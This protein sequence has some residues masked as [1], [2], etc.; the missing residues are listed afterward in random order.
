MM[1]SFLDWKEELASIEP[2]GEMELLRGRAGEST[3]RID[4]TYL[5]SRYRPREEAA[6]L[7][8]DAGL[9]LDRPILVVGLGLGY[10]VAAL[11]ARGATQ[12]AGIEGGKAVA[13]LALQAGVLDAYD[14]LLGLGKMED[15]VDT[16]AYHSFA[17]SLPQVLVH[18][19]TA[20]LHP[21]Y[22]EA[23]VVS[24]SRAALSDKHLHIAVVGPMYGGSLPITGYLERAFRNLGHQ[25]LLVDTSQA[26]D[27]YG[28]V[29]QTVKS[30][31]ASNQLT[32]GLTTLLSEWC[33]ARVA[34]FAPDI[35]IVLAQAPV[36]PQFPLRL[37]KEGI[38]SAFWYVE[39]WRHLPYWKDIAPYYD[40]FFHIQRG[41]FEEKLTAAG[42]PAHAF[43]QTACSSDVHKPVS[44]NGQE[45]QEYGC[46]L[47]FAGAG[48]YNRIEMF[49][50]LTDYS[51][52]IWGVNW[53]VRELQPHVCRPD[54][55]FGPTQFAKMVAGSK[56]SLNL[57][58]STMHEGVDPKC[59]AINPR[60]FE[61]AACG[62]FQLC[63]PCIGLDSLFD[64]E[65]ELPVYRDLTEMRAKIDYYLAHP[66]ERAHIAA[67]A[68]ERVL[69]EHTYE[70]R[71]QQMLDCLIE[72]YGS[73][74][75]RKGVRVQRTMTEMAARV[76]TDTS[77]GSYLSSL[78]PDLLF[79]H[80]NI[81]ALYKRGHAERSYPEKVFAY[82]SEVRDFAE[83]V[84]EMQP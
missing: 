39:N 84:L 10:H 57:H 32:N 56:I 24:L 7:I 46:D 66:D 27:L 40:Y 37:A 22:A 49:R 31:Q 51:F 60:V 11:L 43:V 33:Y 5:H 47:S 19:P 50:A 28:A 3:L 79:T 53:N 67:R 34:E 30:K 17:Q 38:V 14:V 72:Q 74:I 76:G 63:D 48:Y 36:T 45:Q 55:R 26:W 65:S 81:S 21:E 59:D 8:D 18:P 54:E 41:E 80:E 16:S 4:K 64:F 25:T 23:A 44:L 82:L 68:R 20:R 69:R 78:P 13:H 12:V 58:S 52:K 83:T 2:S 15:I 29:T 61:I 6:R 71:A 42:C 9:D 75:L 70:N 1:K 62:G 35:C 77:L 73:R